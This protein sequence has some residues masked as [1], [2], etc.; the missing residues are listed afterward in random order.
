MNLK[1]NVEKTQQA[2]DHLFNSR[3]SEFSDVVVDMLAS[4]LNDAIDNRKHDVAQVL[5]TPQDDQGE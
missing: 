5:L 2:I 1:E 3:P 4:K